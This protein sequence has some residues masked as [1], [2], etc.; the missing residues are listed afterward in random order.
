MCKTGNNQRD[1][2]T[3]SA[4]VNH[5]LFNRSQKPFGEAGNASGLGARSSAGKLHWTTLVRRL[6]YGPSLKCRST[7]ETTRP[8]QTFRAKNWQHNSAA[9]SV[10]VSCL[11]G[12]RHQERASKGPHKGHL[13][14]PSAEL[15]NTQ[16]PLY[17]HS[18]DIRGGKQMAFISKEQLLRSCVV[19]S[20][21]SKRGSKDITINQQPQQPASPGLEK[22]SYK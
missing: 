18:D 19:A 22:Q 11:I 20:I 13:I 16:R 9:P 21:G 17:T 8:R 6:A 14:Y 7:A 12:F 3:A 1:L 15:A 4:K 10:T 5:Q 2:H